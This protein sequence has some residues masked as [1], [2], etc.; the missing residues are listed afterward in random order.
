[1]RKVLLISVAFVA[2]TLASCGNKTDANANADSTATDTTAQVADSTDS[3]ASTVSAIQTGDA[4]AAPATV[5]ALTKEIQA[6]VAAKDTKGL[7]VLLSNAKAKIAE[8]AKTD[9]AAAKAYVS[10]LQQYVNQHAEE[11]KSIAGGNATISQAVD[12]VKNLNP[13]KVVNAVASAATSDAKN[14]A[15]GAAETAKSAAENAVNSKVNEAT[16]AANAAKSKAE[17]KAAK[18]VA[19]AQSK[20]TKAQNKASEA[21]TKT[22]NKAN[23]AVNKAAGKALKGLGL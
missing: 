13:E 8:L 22:Q 10:Q 15:T 19:K 5:A 16:S 14:I 23:D 1:M 21:V 4:K 11:I 6:K 18:E 3:T 20:V 12:E 2:L 17:A 9:P 7:T